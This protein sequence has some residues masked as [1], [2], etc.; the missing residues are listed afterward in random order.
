MCFQFKS[1]Q[2]IGARVLSSHGEAAGFSSNGNESIAAAVGLL[3]DASTNPGGGG[4]NDGS[5]GPMLECD[6]VEGCRLCVLDREIPESFVGVFTGVVSVLGRRSRGTGTGVPI[7]SR[8]A[9]L[10][11]LLLTEP[12]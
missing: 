12:P 11:E 3:V 10:I 9:W 5:M 2:I 8:L 4:K 1:S 6:A 7:G